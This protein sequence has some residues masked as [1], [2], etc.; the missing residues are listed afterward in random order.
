MRL[1]LTALATL[2]AITACT[3][4]VVQEPSLMEQA[5]TLHK[6][7]IILDT[8]HDISVA[9]FTAEKNY[10]MELAT[11]VNLPKM[12]AGLM[13][14]SWLIV[15]TGQGPLT[16]QGY[17]DAYANAVAKFDAIHR[18][19]EEIAPQQIELALTSQDVR[20]IISSGKKVAMIGVENGY[21]IGTDITRVKEF[22]ERGARYMSLAHNGHNQLSDSHTGE[23]EGQWLNNGLSDLGKLAVSEMNK[24]GIMIDISHPSKVANLEMIALS[25]A[26]VIASHSSARALYDHSRNL[27]DEE[28]LA[29]K[30]N[31]GVVQT[32]A[33]RGYV[34]GDKAKTFSDAKKAIYQEIAKEQGISLVPWSKFRTISTEEQ[35]KAR[36]DWL[37][38]ESLSTEKIAIAGSNIDQVDVA[39]FVDHIDYMVKLIG[40]DHVGISSDFDGGG[41]IKGWNDAS[42][43]LNVTVELIKRG[44]S[45]QEIAKLWGENLLRV[46]D[47]VQRVASQMQETN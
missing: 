8:H 20:S 21:P 36:A 44:Y 14:V 39:D 30:E 34:N 24:W 38:V 15:Y 13:D 37:L 19:V 31:G 32:V 46:L 22:A 3:D 42:E 29:V 18:L 27:D 4:P 41:G 47:E 10:T 40:I 1:K 28:L 43:T 2:F 17:K 35:N 11:Q 5:Q 7:I 12:D 16:E 25:K 26:P 33:F 6:K 23:S 9:N 45:D